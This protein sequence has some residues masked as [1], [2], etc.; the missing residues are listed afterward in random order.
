MESPIIYL[1]GKYGR[2]EVRGPHFVC[3]SDLTADKFKLKPSMDVSDTC[4]TLRL[5]I[6]IESARRAH[7]RVGFSIIVS[8]WSFDFT[9]MQFCM[10]EMTR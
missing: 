8:I 3:E 1:R 7:Q 2:K 4:T 5:P 9:R 10:P 6:D